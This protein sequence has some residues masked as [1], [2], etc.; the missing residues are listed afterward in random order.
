M[1]PTIADF[2]FDEKEL[3]VELSRETMAKLID[4]EKEV[5]RLKRGIGEIQGYLEE[6]EPRIGDAT[7]VC[8]A[9]LA[10]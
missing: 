1:Q 5:A 8:D 2:G 7:F 4:A 10:D 9:L 6:P 3:L